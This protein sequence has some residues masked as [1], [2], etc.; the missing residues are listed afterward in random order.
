[1]DTMV[2]EGGERYT[3]PEIAEAMKAAGTPLSRAKWQYLSAGNGPEPTD[4]ALLENLAA[5]FKVPAEFLTHEG[6][7]VPQRVQAQ[8]ELLRA[9]RGAKVKGMATRLLSD[10]SPEVALQIAAV[11]DAEL[12][13][14]QA[15]K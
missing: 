6:S 7:E 4:F 14:K 11:I 8:L 13:N 15:S 5:F 9:A 12:G 3:Y 2:A 10:L 1:M